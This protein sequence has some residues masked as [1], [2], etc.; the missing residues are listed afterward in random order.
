MPTQ[1]FICELKDSISSMSF[2]YVPDKIT[3]NTS[4]KYQEIDIA[5]RSHPIH[6]WFSG[7]DTISFTLP[8][9]SA[10]NDENYVNQRA[11]FLQSLTQ[12]TDVVIGWGD[13]FEDYVWVLKSV[14]IEHSVFQ[15]NA[16][17]PVISA[18]TLNLSMN[19]EKSVSIAARR[20]GFP[21]KGNP[22]VSTPEIAPLNPVSLSVA[23]YKPLTPALS[24]PIETQATTNTNTLLSYVQSSLD[25][26][27]NSFKA[28]T[29][30]KVK[31]LY[32]PSYLG[33]MSRQA[34]TTIF[35]KTQQTMNS[36]LAVSSYTSADKRKVFET[37]SNQH[38]NYFKD[39]GGIK[40]VGLTYLNEVNLD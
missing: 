28:L 14:D 33:T 5:N 30:A 26:N 31:E 4:G 7:S 17:M 21:S 3:H 1:L 39:K 25:I 19:P 9:A 32:D 10:T 37:V 16:N 12:G 38:L 6:L 13:L 27:A 24:L 35:N 2:D 40:V 34:Q 22:I 36:V 18:A 29:K 23:N 20:K 8:L 15:G 11:R